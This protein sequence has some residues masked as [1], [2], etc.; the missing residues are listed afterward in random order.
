MPD[1]LLK[2]KLHSLRKNNNYTQNDIAQYLNMTRAG[3]GHYEKGKRTPD[4]QTLLKLAKLYNIEINEFI[5]CK[6]TPIHNDIP[7][8]DKLIDN[9][10][11]FFLNNNPNLKD[12][13]LY[14][15]TNSI[16]L[17]NDEI[18]LINNYRKASIKDKKKLLYMSNNIGKEKPSSLSN[19]KTTI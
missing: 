9:E 4:Y 15:G 11:A 19:K 14:E 16:L 3:Y 12:T 6:T 7:D 10:V 18:I 2:D 13:K 17:S 1:S 8:D 5:N